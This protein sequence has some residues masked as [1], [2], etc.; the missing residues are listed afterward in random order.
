MC[1]RTK[2]SLVSRQSQW[3]LVSFL[4][5]MRP[6][7]LSLFLFVV[8][9][10]SSSAPTWA[11]QSV[12]KARV[13]DEH[14]GEALQGV[15]VAVEGTTLGGATDSDGVVAISGIP[16]GK[17][18]IVFSFVGYETVKLTV[19]FP[20]SDPDFLYEIALEESHE[21]LEEVS[22]SATRTSRT[23][24]DQATRVET[25]AGEEIEE[26]IS[27]EPG[28]I[29]MLLNES[30]GINVQQTSAVT[31]GSSI[32]IQGLDD[33][34]TQ[35][36]K[37]GFPLFGGFSGGLSLL[38]VPPLDLQQVEVIKGPS[39]ILYGGDAIAGLINLVSKGPTEDSQLSLLANA[40]TAG[41]IDLGSFYTNRGERFGITFLATGNNQSPYDPDDDS[42]A[43]LPKTS[44]ITLNPK[45]FYYPNAS[46]TL[47]L[48]ISGTV[49]ERTGGDM[50]VLNHGVS[51]TRTFFE[52]NSSTRLSSQFRVDR[53]LNGSST[54]FLKGDG[55][56]TFKN[57][58]SFFDRKIEV[59]GYQF[60]GQV[61]FSSEIAVTMTGR[62]V[63]FPLE[64]L[65]ERKSSTL[66]SV[67]MPP[68][69]LLCLG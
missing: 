62:T 22:V 13:F 42:F 7:P 18:T 63:D 67:S 24:A 23:I 27:M 8:L 55:V 32:Q 58:V 30:P 11:Q 25:I 39:S 6:A 45:L 5:S 59:P 14:E 56:L 15:N 64:L 17:Q 41:G 19:T 44:R 65:T 68:E 36:L 3:P 52:E 69:R 37:D 38:Q 47:S 29:S 51:S 50:E 10:L 46:T 12:F 33:R 20:T 2:L 26:K 53:K 16:T 40:T 4:V 21:E 61:S 49:E 9:L 31:G 54:N 66:A 28:N 35:I 43:N 60:E 48:G 1:H 34:Y 57:S